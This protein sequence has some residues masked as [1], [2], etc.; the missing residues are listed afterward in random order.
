MKKILLLCFMALLTSGCVSTAKKNQLDYAIVKNDLNQ[1]EVYKLCL[2]SDAVICGRSIDAQGRPNDHFGVAGFTSEQDGVFTI[3]VFMLTVVRDTRLGFDTVQFHFQN[4]SVSSL[5]MSTKLEFNSI[6]IGDKEILDNQFQASKLDVDYDVRTT[7]QNYYVGRST[8]LDNK[9]IIT[10]P[11]SKARELVELS[12]EVNLSVISPKN[13][14]QNIK[15]ELNE[16]IVNAV[17]ADLS[18]I[19]SI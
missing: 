6:K 9:V 2:D 17:Q 14:L 1:Q 4:T 13:G 16:Q 3:D 19:K 15:L 18:K 5:S 7:G 8:Q 11:L 12:G 10:L